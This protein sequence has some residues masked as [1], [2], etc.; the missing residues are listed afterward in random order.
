MK[1]NIF[2]LSAAALINAATAQVDL[3]TAGNYVVLAKTAITGALGSVIY[4]DIAVSPI[5]HTAITGMGALPMDENGSG[6]FSTSPSVVS[7]ENRAADATHPGHVFAANYSPDT[8]DSLIIAV[9][10]MVT[11]YNNAKAF[12]LAGEAPATENLKGGFIGGETLTS[13]VYTFNTDINIAYGTNL[14][15]DGDADAVFVIQ[16]TKNI[17]QAAA[18]QVILLNDAK[19]ENIFWQVAGNVEVGNG[20]HLEGTLL[21]KTHVTLITGS[22]LK[23]R[24]LAQT[25]CTLQVDATITEAW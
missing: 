14:Y 23:G 5:A 15:I 22:S 13:G 10:D 18:T 8:E 9:D 17:V 20:A 1:L 2:F 19:A 21:V 3:G 6:D 7:S 16:T 25:A 24:V 12:P 4:G 11:A